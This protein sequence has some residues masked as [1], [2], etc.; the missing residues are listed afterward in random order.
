MKYTI[1][2]RFIKKS[3]VEEFLSGGT[4]QIPPAFLQEGMISGGTQK[5]PGFGGGFTPPVATPPVATPPVATPPAAT[6]PAGGIF[7]GGTT[8]TTPEKQTTISITSVHYGENCGTEIN[9]GTSLEDIKSKCNGKNNCDYLI[10]HNIIGDPSP[11]CAKDYK[12]NFKCG[13]EQQDRYAF[14]KKEASGKNINLTC[15]QQGPPVADP[16]DQEARELIHEINFID[17]EKIEKSGKMGDHKM[18]IDIEAPI[19]TQFEKQEFFNILNRLKLIS[20]DLKKNLEL[21]LAG[22]PVTDLP[23]QIK[24]YKTVIKEMQT[25]FLNLFDIVMDLRKQYK[26]LDT[27]TMSVEKLRET[28]ANRKAWADLVK[29]EDKSLIVQRHKEYSEVLIY[30]EKNLELKESGKPEIDLPEHLYAKY[31][32]G[33][34]ISLENMRGGVEWRKKMIK[35]DEKKLIMYESKQYRLSGELN[36]KLLVYL[37]KNLELKEAGNPEI[38]VPE[39][40][41]NDMY[42]NFRELEDYTK[43]GIP[44]PSDAVVPPKAVPPNPV[45]I[46]NAAIKGSGLDNTLILLIVF[47][48]FFYKLRK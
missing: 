31:G 2:G 35:Q 1:D 8:S 20:N 23:K 13:D 14:E 19:Y 32:G 27:K 26:E 30:E 4:Q 16:T 12:V 5:L 6:P 41:I 45:A 17:I 11:G 39:Q 48:V 40:I 33:A 9:N 29:G 46:Y 42:V 47:A 43:R 38:D 3:I 18:S 21:K 28:I 34:S 10:N 44:L 15:T 36:N 25:A 7:G 22:K 37:M 24:E